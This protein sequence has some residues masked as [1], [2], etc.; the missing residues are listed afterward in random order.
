[1]LW[2]GFGRAKESS[3]VFLVKTHKTPIDDQPAI[4]IVR[5]GRSALCSL[6]EYQRGFA[7]ND[8]TAWLLKLICGQ[9]FC[10]S[11]SEHYRRWHDGSLSPLLTVRYEELVTADDQLLRTLAAFIGYEGAIAPWVNP[12]EQLKKLD[13]NRFREGRIEWS[14]HPSWNH[15]CETE[16][17]RL[18]RKLMTELGYGSA[19]ITAEFSNSVW[20]N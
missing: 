11:W 5:D 6:L 8:P 14:S 19:S 10:G 17:W 9:G 20:P 4:Y 2:Y 16:F 12:F 1:M 18:H 3:E 13:P 15:T 7:G